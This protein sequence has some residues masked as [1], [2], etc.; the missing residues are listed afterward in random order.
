VTIRTSPDDFAECAEVQSGWR[1]RATI[2]WRKNLI[3][4]RGALSEAWVVAFPMHDFGTSR[5]KR[6]PVDSFERACDRAVAQRTQQS[7]R[8]KAS[9]PTPQ[10]TIEA[11]L[12]CVRERG[13]SALKEPANVERLRRCDEA[14]R[15]Q[16]NERIAKLAGRS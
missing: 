9:V 15:R 7:Q 16:V 10:V 14:A 8:P 3:L 4:D 6:Y 13:P 12:Y 11:I 2:S 5:L 1:S